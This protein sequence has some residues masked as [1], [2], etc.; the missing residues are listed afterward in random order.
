MAE[1]S[2]LLDHHLAQ[3]TMYPIGTEISHAK[4]IYIYDKQ[5]NAFMDM[6]CGIGVSNW[7]H[8]NE[9]VNQAI[10]D[11]VDKH[12]HV[13]VYGEFLQEAQV[14]A[15][16]NLIALMPD[17]L[18]T[19]YFVNSGTEAIE[20]ALKLAK[21]ITG[22][23]QLMAIE[24]SYHGNTH[25]AMSVSHN[26]HKKAAFRPLLPDVSFL[27]Y[28]DEQALERITHRTACVLIETVQ[29]DAGVRLHS[30][31]YMQKL[32]AR[33]TEMG[34]MLILDEIQCGLGRTGSVHAFEAK[35]IIP[36]ILVLG[37]SLAGGLPV[38]CV[39]AAKEHMQLFTHNPM[40]G[41]I[42]TFAGHPVVC[43]AV[44]ANL[45]RYR[46]RLAEA[47]VESKGKFITDYFASHS[48]I[49]GMRREG[50]MLAFDFPSIDDVNIILDRCMERGFIAF[51]FLSR[52]MSIRWA[53]PLNITF[54]E[55][56][57][58]CQ[59]FDEACRY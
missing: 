44:A 54:E 20:A 8:G 14:N 30:A 34:A 4:G 41:H 52:P 22:R 10:K 35:G 11:Q 19:C 25:G 7:G 45:D 42:S 53:P 59:L 50:L 51:R 6:V 18:D 9:A 21:R 49:Q 58:A 40:L 12:L 32:R 24:G 31:A 27:P 46:E 57:K 43:A 1:H 16:R 15:A 2:L 23:T 13:M 37:K 48:V 29:G 39:V 55:L 56:N 3:T 47:Q 38:G 26:E 28:H 17:P 36:D 5:G 33:C